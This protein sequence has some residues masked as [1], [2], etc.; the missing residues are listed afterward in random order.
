MLRFKIIAILILCAPV[1]VSAAV[2]DA[3][4][5]VRAED[6]RIVPSPADLIAGQTAR[7]YAMV[8][9][10]G[11][12]DVKGEVLFYM[13]PQLIGEQQPVSLR[14]QGFADEVFADFVVPQGAF[15][16]LVRVTEDGVGTDNNSLNDEAVTPLITPLPDKDN[17]G[18]TDSK[19]NCP[20]MSNL[21]QK[22][23]D[24]DGVGDACDPDDDNDGL[25]DI[26]EAARGTNP[27]DPDTDKDGISDAKDLHPLVVDKSPL[28][29]KDAAVVV[30]AP[31]V[32]KKPVAPPVEPI[33]KTEP[34][35]E[36]APVV[37]NNEEPVIK[38]QEEEKEIITKT[39]GQVGESL[40]DQLNK[41]IK[42]I[43]PGKMFKLWIAA[44]ISALLAGMFAFMALYMKTPRD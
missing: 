44:G 20:T 23:N 30:P 18:L 5:G 8:H 41:V 39:E 34:K 32:E 17:D 42:K 35:I 11:N 13:G 15:N 33:K 6:I 40:N 1:F 4:I 16:I 27:N 43:P 14:A 31:V 10:Y 25:A 7:I 36:S 37:K 2:G 22:D 24:G 9:N 28:E 21:N 26:D 38:D 12:A 19:D 3:D 29:K